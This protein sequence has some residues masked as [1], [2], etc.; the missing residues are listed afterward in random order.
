M[1]ALVVC[2]CVLYAHVF[3]VFVKQAEIADLSSTM[4]D[5]L[6]F[7]EVNQEGLTK[8]QRL[9]IQIEVRC[10]SI[11]KHVLHNLA[12]HYIILHLIITQVIDLN[13]FAC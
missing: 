13:R 5:K 2:V 10:Y 8:L 4:I 3:T 1:S 6:E 11:T 12:L 7:L 9:R